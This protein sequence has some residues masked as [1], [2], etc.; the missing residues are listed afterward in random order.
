MIKKLLLISLLFLF[1]FRSFSQQKVEKYC[2]VF[3]TSRVF[4]KGVNVFIDLGKDRSL[5]PFKNTS[6]K[7]DLEHV[8]KY[9]TVVDALNYMSSL[10]W[11]MVNSTSYQV[12]GNTDRLNFY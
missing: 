11:S 10:G 9:T 1:S 6:V 8:K 5:L 12:G 3:M 2:E 7:E 4:S